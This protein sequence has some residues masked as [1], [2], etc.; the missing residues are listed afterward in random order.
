MD[1][2]MDECPAL[3]VHWTVFTAPMS[4]MDR[5]Q[6]IV[7]TSP[8]CLV[9]N[10]S[11]SSS[12]LLMKDSCTCRDARWRA[13]SGAPLK[14]SARRARRRV[15]I[16]QAVLMEIGLSG[17]HFVFHACGTCIR[18]RFYIVDSWSLVFPSVSHPSR[19]RFTCPR[20]YMPS[21]FP[22]YYT[23]V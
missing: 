6:T 18:S 9:D 14:G 3:R 13:F 12:T 15:S 20:L 17:P 16:M 8:A 21:Q 11:S 4:I 10:K 5:Y 1:R 2:P 22:A 19:M 7:W 23:R